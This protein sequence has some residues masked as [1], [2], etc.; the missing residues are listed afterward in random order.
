[1]TKLP[2]KQLVLYLALSF[3]P[4]QSLASI[5]PLFQFAAGLLN[6]GQF[7]ESDRYTTDDDIVVL[8]NDGV[9]L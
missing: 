9:E 7:P 1:M 8:T 6:K 3:V 4:I 2:L 5:Q